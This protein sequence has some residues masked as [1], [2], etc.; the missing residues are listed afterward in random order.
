[1]KCTWQECR[2]KALR[3]QR[4]KQGN[5]WARLC[6]KHHEELEL[7]IAVGLD[8]ETSARDRGRIVL[9]AWIMAVGGSRRAA[10]RMLR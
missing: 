10:Q 5:I 6:Q 2:A 9:K 7:A 3:P 4:D 8:P 1:M